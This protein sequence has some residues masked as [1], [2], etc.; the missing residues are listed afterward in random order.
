MNHSQTAGTRFLWAVLL[1]FCL[2]FPIDGFSQR[3]VVQFSGLVVSGEQ[4]FGVPFASIYVPKTTRGAVT[5]DIGF[6]S[7]PL[8]TGDTCL[9]R[10]QGF[11]TQKYVIPNDGRE[12]IS[13]VLYLQADTTLLPA[14]EILPFPT[15]EDFKRAFL[16][17]KLPEGDL[18][19]MRRNLDNNLLA[20]MQYNLGMDAGLN[21]MYFQNQQT[22]HTVNRNF[23]PTNQL[24]NP[25]AWGKFIESVKRGDLK[26]KRETEDDD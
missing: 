12:S 10:S 2:W 7:F 1:L 23:V 22:Y 5:N 26:K 17:L 8:L 6:F 13:V 18:N 15:E 20:R 24:I 11:R 19:R 25:F 16:A 21:H 14:V 9:V 3:R 4:S